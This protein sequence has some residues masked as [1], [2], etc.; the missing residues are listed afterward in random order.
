MI[1]SL[2]FI[3]IKKRKKIKEKN[4]KKFSETTSL[5]P[6]KRTTIGKEAVTTTWFTELVF[7]IL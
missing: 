6:I 2:S 3:G 1:L 7:K 4:G 5:M